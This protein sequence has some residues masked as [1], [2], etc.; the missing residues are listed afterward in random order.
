M[1]ILIA[2]DKFKG[3]LSAVQVCEIIAGALRQLRGDLDIKSIPLADGGEGTGELLTTMCGGRTIPVTVLDPLLRPIPSGFG[4][5]ADGK[6]AVVEM[7]RASGLQLLKSKERNPKV[8]S[9]F[10]TG[11]L[12]DAAME[13]GVNRV[14]LGVGGS[15]TNDAGTGMAEALGFEF[16]DGLHQRIKPCGQHLALMTTF[17]ERK[18]HSKINE[19]RF[20]VIH[21]VRNPFYGKEGASFIYSP[22]KGANP[23]MVSQLDLGLEH[24]ARLAKSQCDVELQ[25]PGAGAGGGL[26]GGARLFLNA[27]FQ[28]GIEFVMD[29]AN[30]EEHIREADLV[31]TGEGKIDDQTLQGKVV[32][33]VGQLA[34]R[35]RKMCIA[36]A[37]LN[38]ASAASL[39]TM[40]IQQV[41]ELVDAKT[42]ERMAMVQAAEILREKALTAL[43]P[44]LK[45]D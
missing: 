27:Q 12:I 38:Q 21:D 45:Q 6:T 26:A 7:A 44:W 20:V 8:T 42:P 3:S 28:P 23:G 16:F 30:M 11:Q 19:T 37:G 24:F 32:A 33:G 31:I 39:Q 2:P 29:F 17:S 25:F 15:A 40:G 36:F 5:S 35:H 1:K 18:K 9:S 34:A 41:V 10:G 22:Q 14:V 4:L 43:V 13:R